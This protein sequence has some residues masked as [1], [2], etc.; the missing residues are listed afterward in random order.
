MTFQFRACPFA[1]SIRISIMKRTRSATLL[2][3]AVILASLALA[4][5]MGPRGWPGVSIDGDSIYVGS[6]KGEVFAYNQEGRREWRWEPVV[7][8]EGGGFLAC[9]SGA[10]QFRAG[11]FYGP[12]VVVDG[13]VYIGSYSG[14]VYAIDAETGNDVW[15]HDIETPIAASVAVS[16]DSVFVGGS[17]G[18]LYAIDLSI[19]RPKVGFVP[20][21]TNDKIWS[22]PAVQGDTVYFGSLDH[23]VYAIDAGTGE[24]RWDEPFQTR[25][26]IGS[27]PMIVDGIVLIGS[28]DSR[29]YGIEA[30]TG[31]MRWAFEEAGNWFWM[32]PARDGGTIYA[33]S[34]DGKV[35][36]L[37]TGTGE[38]AS[39]WP[40]PF[41][42]GGPI[43]SSPVIVGDVLVL[44]TE[45]GNVIGVDLVSG[46][47]AWSA[48]LEI[49]VF[50]PLAASGGN[51]FVNAQDNRLYAFDGATGRQVW[52][53][54]L[55]D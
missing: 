11:L 10:G 30:S 8:E 21:E 22:A 48:D 42:A 1:V 54:G 17:D 28:F 40:S 13:V 16:G 46:E 14:S 12:P 44:A 4:G 32:L 27:T 33:G 47:Q 31:N 29:F 41:D 45:S 25:G 19:G 51:A 23:S 52:S 7:E 15:S 6:I 35:Y 49:K 9:G 53:V 55:G 36:P 38:L 43:K 34:M 18:K 26:G 37:D 20:Y 50:A 3:L 5:C 39:V 2:L 24:L